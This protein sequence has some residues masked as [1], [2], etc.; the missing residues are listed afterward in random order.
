MIIIQY[1]NKYIIHKEH[2]RNKLGGHGLHKTKFLYSCSI[3]DER[4]V[5]QICFLKDC[6]D[7]K[8]FRLVESRFH[9]IGPIYLRECFP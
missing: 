5:K 4:L 7:G 1:M 6:R 2:S 8:F 3:L 9:G